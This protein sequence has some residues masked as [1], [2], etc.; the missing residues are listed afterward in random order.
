MVYPLVKQTIP[1]SGR[2]YSPLFFVYGIRVFIEDKLRV[3]QIALR[4]QLLR[5]TLVYCAKLSP[6]C[7]DGVNL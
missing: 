2:R 6:M 7:S 3:L 1:I 5:S 4:E